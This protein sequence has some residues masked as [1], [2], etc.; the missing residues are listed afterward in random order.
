MGNGVPAAEKAIC[1]FAHLTFEAVCREKR[2]ALLGVGDVHLEVPLPEIWEGK[3]G[4]E[5]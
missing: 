5:D 2:L 3:D 4:L 1:E